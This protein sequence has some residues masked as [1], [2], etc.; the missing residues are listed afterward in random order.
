MTNLTNAQFVRDTLEY[1]TASRARRIQLETKWGP[2]AGALRDA[3]SFDDVQ[4][5]D[6]RAY[7][8]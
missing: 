1:K 4:E 8:A 7:E 6:D 5:G 3:A 2:R